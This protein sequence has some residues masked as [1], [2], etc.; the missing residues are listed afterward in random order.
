M[1]TT[2]QAIQQFVSG[3][4]MALVGV[5]SSG[6][7]FGNAACVELRKRG[8]RVLPVHPTATTIKGEACW[9]SLAALPEKV[10]RA[11]VVVQPEGTEAVVREAAAAGVRYVWLQQGSESSTA[12][13]AGEDLGLGVVTGQCILMFAEPVGFHG[14]HRWLWK[15]LGKIPTE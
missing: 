14:I 8:Y 1:A 4:T 9:P 7:G 11:L 2:A 6:K 15:I 3:K 12:I 13:K 5:S 10:E